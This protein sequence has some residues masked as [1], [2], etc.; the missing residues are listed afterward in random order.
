MRHLWNG[1]QRGDFNPA[2]LRTTSPRRGATGRLWASDCVYT[3][4]RASSQ[5]IIATVQSMTIACCHSLTVVTQSEKT[6]VAS[7]RRSYGPTHRGAF[8]AIA[9]RSERRYRFK[10]GQ[11]VFYHP[12]GQPRG[13]IGPFR[14]VA[15]IHQPD[16][17]ILYEIKNRSRKLLA[18]ADELKLALARR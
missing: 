18:R 3:P 17:E 16:S 1:Y 13:R 7:A 14:V 6:T 15:I 11:E 10:V 2:I 12:K 9:G 4:A 8:V 5:A